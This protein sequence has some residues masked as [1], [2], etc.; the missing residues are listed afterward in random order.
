LSGWNGK[1]DDPSDSGMDMQQ[2]AE[3]RRTH[4]LVDAHGTAHRIQAYAA[5]KDIDQVIE[6]A[7]LFGACGIGINVPAGADEQFDKQQPWTVE[8]NA[9][10]AGGHYIPVVGRNSQ[11][12]LMCITWGYLHAMTPEFVERYMDE[13]IAYLSPDYLTAQ[14]KSPEMLDMTALENSLKALA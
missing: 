6:A 13:A 9:K 2:V 3:W 14:G 7:Y 5:I 11:G 4:G 12:N 10:M 1:Q 8:P